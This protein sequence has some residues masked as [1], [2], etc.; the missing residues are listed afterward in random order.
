MTVMTG[1]TR[2][3]WR[4]YAWVAVVLLL[5]VPLQ[6]AALMTASSVTSGLGIGDPEREHFAIVNTLLGGLLMLIA[7][8]VTGRLLGLG[9]ALW[10]GW[11]FAM[12]IL[13]APVASYVFFADIRSG[14]Y[15]ETDQAL[16]EILIPY[17]LVLLASA[18]I[19]H[20]LAGAQPARRAWAWVVW[21]TAAM[22]ILLI[23]L[24]VAKM[25]TSGGDFAL[26]SPLTGLVLA[27]AGA[28]AVVV[29]ARVR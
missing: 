14:F 18:A 6:L 15:L 27:I 1:T 8:P 20:R 29:A 7:V 25:A 12:P 21:S 23:G 24:T 2:D 26:D 11:P 19:G 10:L 28:Y 4:G 13:L 16:P 22:T 3:T 5:F 17:A 9:V